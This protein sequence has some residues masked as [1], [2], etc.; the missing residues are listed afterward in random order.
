MAAISTLT[1]QTGSAVADTDDFVTV[2]VSDTTQ[3]AGGTTKR[4]TR[5]E[6]QRALAPSWTGYVPALIQSASVAHTVTLAR[7]LL[8]GKLMHVNLDIVATASGSSGVKI[9][10]G[11]PSSSDSANGWSPVANSSGSSVLGHG[12][13]ALSGTVYQVTAAFDQINSGTTPLVQMLRADVTGN[14]PAGVSPSVALAN[15]DRMILNLV[16][17]VS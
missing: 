7:F 4:I 5:L 16:Y 12:Q 9:L 1:A 14:S 13:V 17:E 15:G 6:L 3:G 2:D 10:P 8:L 11:L